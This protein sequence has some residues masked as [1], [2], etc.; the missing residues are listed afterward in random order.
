MSG[1]GISPGVA[2]GN[3]WGSL[4]KCL[5][6]D[7]GYWLGPCQGNGQNTHTRLLQVAWAFSGDGGWVPRGSVLRKRARGML[8][9]FSWPSL[10]VTQYYSATF[11]LLV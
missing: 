8:Y 2:A 10:E 4:P 5:E 1:L 11:Y 9:I 6:V 3:I 7:V